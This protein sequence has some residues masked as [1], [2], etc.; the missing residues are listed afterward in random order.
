[1]LGAFRSLCHYRFRKAPARQ[2]AG[3]FV[4]G[5]PFR[6]RTRGG[7]SERGRKGNSLEEGPLPCWCSGVTFC[8]FFADVLD[9][10]EIVKMEL[11][12]TQELNLEGLRESDI[13]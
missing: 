4:E 12:P 2:A 8:I 3:G 5:V 10:G 11:S 7:E 6:G 9:Y 1:M 13:G